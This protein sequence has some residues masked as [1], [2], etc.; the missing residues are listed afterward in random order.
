MKP[1]MP[2]KSMNCN[3][4]AFALCALAAL[5]ASAA[6]KVISINF[7]SARQ[8]NSS[9]GRIVGEGTFGAYPVAASGWYNVE[10]L[11]QVVTDASGLKWQD[12]T[13]CDSDITYSCTAATWSKDGVA[14]TTHNDDLFYCFLNDGQGKSEVSLTIKGLTAENAVPSNCR[15]YVYLS[16]HGTAEDFTPVYVNGTLYTFADGAV[17][18]TNSATA[19]WGDV[20][21]ANI[22]S[23]YK[24][25]GDLVL[26]GDYLVVPTVVSSEGTITVSRPAC[27]AC[28]AA[29]RC[30]IAAVQLVFDDVA[31]ATWTGGGND[32]VWTNSANWSCTDESGD[33]ISSYPGSLSTVT[34]SNAQLPANCDW[35]ALDVTK[36]TA[37]SSIDL[38]GHDLALSIAKGASLPSMT[39]TDTSAQGAGGTFTLT[40]ADGAEIV[41][42]T[43]TLSGTLKFVKDGTGSF[44]ASKAG[45]SY[46]G[47][48]RIAAGAATVGVENAPFG[49]CNA[50]QTIRI[51]EGA[52]LVFNPFTTDT[53]VY[54]DIYYNYELAGTIMRSQSDDTLAYARSCRW[55]TGC[56]LT[57]PSDATEGH[58]SGYKF[59]LD[60]TFS[61]NGKTLYIDITSAD[62]T[63]VA[64]TGAQGPFSTDATGGAI[65]I[66]GKAKLQIYQDVDLSSAS[67]HMGADSCIDYQFNGNQ[68]VGVTDFSYECGTW[69]SKHAKTKKVAVS[70][71]YTAST[72]RPPVE[73]Q[74]G[75]TIDLSGLAECLAL[76]G[77][78]AA[79]GAGTFTDAGA[80]TFASGTITVNLAGRDIAALASSGGYV[81]TWDGKPDG[82]VFVLDAISSQDGKYKIFADS[83]GILVKRRC[84]LIISFF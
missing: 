71:V 5:S 12:G 82:V 16:A 64:M 40:V 56:T 17:T 33:P 41:N 77:K 70:G 43:L 42:T 19:Y 55:L 7:A 25:A 22:G 14:S 13:A 62:T 26:G 59:S 44:S 58:I 34:F 8:S 54:D 52:T 51:D 53:S 45:Q 74:N 50:T 37:G 36:I 81:A 32:G 80:V 73:L 4:A 24:G 57:I 61:L 63:T 79:T 23:P 30:S 11:G 9:F 27:T 69:H 83:T 6:D 60:G 75:A 72:N 68:T 46:T 31:A 65:S 10:N 3:L 84:G 21:Y 78:P 47:G 20:N 29:H 28:T 67:L 2:I 35:S 38:N 76:T 15:V 1:S 49:P 39:I 18:S 66:G 48:T